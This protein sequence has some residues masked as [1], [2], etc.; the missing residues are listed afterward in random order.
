MIDGKYRR[1]EFK[2]EKDVW[3]VIDSLIDETKML[4]TTKGEDFDIALAVSAQ[5]PLFACPNVVFDEQ[6][7]KEIGR[8]IYCMDFGIS[9]YNGSYGEQPNR[10]LDTYKIIKH[11]TQVAEKRAMKDAK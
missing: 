4:N 5:L 7:N 1:V 10:W 8:Y 6:A 3:K 11:A 2:G 9:P